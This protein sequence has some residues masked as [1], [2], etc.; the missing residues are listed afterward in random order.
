MIIIDELDGLKN[1]DKANLY[2]FIDF[3]NQQQRGV[4]KIVISNTLDLFSKIKNTQNTLDFDVMS[5]EPYDKN[6]LVKMVG[7]VFNQHDLVRK[8]VGDRIVRLVCIKVSDQGGDIRK[9]FSAM[10]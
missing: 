6:Q 9:F 8:V 1:K 3:L 4:A 5:F 7:G 2:Y 10:H